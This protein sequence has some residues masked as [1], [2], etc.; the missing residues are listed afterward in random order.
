MKNTCMTSELEKEGNGIFETLADYAGI[1]SFL[2]PGVVGIGAYAIAKKT[3]T[4]TTAEI[5]NVQQQIVN[6]ELREAIG[7]TQN[8][9]ERQKEKERIYGN[10]ERPRS[11][12]L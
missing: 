7:V 1:A 3:A 12:M 2:I 11:L 10:V 6:D 9:L 8:K 4:P 5:A